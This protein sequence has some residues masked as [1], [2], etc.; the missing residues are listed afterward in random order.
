M[1]QIVMDVD[2]SDCNW[3]ILSDFYMAVENCPIR[4]E[5]SHVEKGKIHPKCP[6]KFLSPH[7]RL[8][9][10]DA[11]ISSTKDAY[12]EKELTGQRGTLHVPLGGVFKEYV[13]EAPTIL[14]SNR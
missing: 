3:C 6:L 9:D 4:K 5:W 11:F 10:A 13:D 7:G 8:I 12:G 14:E 1:S 2:F